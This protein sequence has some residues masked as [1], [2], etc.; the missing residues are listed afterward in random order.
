MAKRKAA[1]VVTEPESI[2]GIYTTWPECQ[3]AISGVSG[4]KYQSVDSLE[5]AQSMLDGGVRLPPGRWVFTDG[6]GGGG[7]G[8]AIVKVDAGG[9]T[10]SEEISSNIYDV[11]VGSGIPELTT[12]EDVTNAFSRMPNTLAELAAF[13]HAL[14]TIDAAEEVTIVYDYEGIRAWMQRDWQRDDM[15]VAAVIDACWDI[16]RKRSLK[17][18]YRHQRGHQSSWAAPDDF[19]F[20]NDRV[21]ELARQGGVG[22]HGTIAK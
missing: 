3:A 2:R 16:E 17:L 19:A 9:A 14:G 6:S 15:V 20:W 5:K 12:T 1:Y 22:Q 8:I 21:D 7:A 4:V 11:F 13:F 18:K 10:T